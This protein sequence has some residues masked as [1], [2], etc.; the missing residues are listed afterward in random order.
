MIEDRSEKLASTRLETV[1]NESVT[2]SLE[3]GK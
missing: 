3:Q 2:V 1:R